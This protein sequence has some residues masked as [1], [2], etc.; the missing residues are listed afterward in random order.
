MAAFFHSD[1]TDSAHIASTQTAVAGSPYPADG[2]EPR[3]QKQKAH[4]GERAFTCIRVVPLTG[5]EL[6]TF[7]LRMRCSTD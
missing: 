6:V 7:A 1:A 5:I 3:P 2:D 4:S